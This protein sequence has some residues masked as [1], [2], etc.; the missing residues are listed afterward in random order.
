MSY[1]DY[2]RDLSDPDIDPNYILDRYFHSGIPAVFS[3]ANPDEEARLKNDV[4]RGLFGAFQLRVHPYQLQI[5]GSAHLGY[6]PVPDKLG[7]PFNPEVSDIDIAVVSQELFDHWW[8][9]LQ[10]GGLD[11]ATRSTVSRDLFFGFINPAVVRDVSEMGGRWWSTF[12]SLRT[13][14][15][16]GVRGRLYRTYWSMQSY[17]RLAVLRGREKLLALAAD[18]G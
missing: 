5:A 9:E 13:D 4:A 11:A 10:T 15:A 6:S 17:H 7:K 1:A 3:G 2:K 16:V 8:T 12:G 18:V 14:R